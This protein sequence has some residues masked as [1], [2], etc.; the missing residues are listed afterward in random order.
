MVVMLINVS[1]FLFLFIYF[2]VGFL[3]QCLWVKDWVTGDLYG[4]TKREKALTLLGMHI[5][6]ALAIVY[7]IY[8]KVR[9]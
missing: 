1:I 2:W 9:E 6:L 3:A 8:K 4:F 7:S 5:V